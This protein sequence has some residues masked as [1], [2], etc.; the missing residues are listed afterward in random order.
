M[1]IVDNT[2]VGEGVAALAEKFGPIDIVFNNAGLMPLSDIDALQTDEWHRMVDVNIK[3]VLN[4]TAA[5]SPYMIRKR[6]GHIINTTSIAGRKFSPASRS[7]APQSMRSP[8][9]R[10]G[11][12]SNSGK[13]QH[14]GFLHTARCRRNRTL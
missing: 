12:V 9:F 11:C 8:H 3:G 13:T 7:T 10:T 14:S 6:S 1:D 4:T 2:S 5:V